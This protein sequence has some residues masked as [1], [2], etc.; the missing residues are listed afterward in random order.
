MYISVLRNCENPRR[1]LDLFNHHIG[2][3]EENND[4]QRDCRNEGS[5]NSVV[6]SLSESLTF[7]ST[8]FG[9]VYSFGIEG[10]KKLNDRPIEFTKN[11]IFRKNRN[12]M[13]SRRSL[14]NSRLRPFESIN[15]YVGSQLLD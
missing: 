5:D 1:L 11:E 7:K 4:G 12:E 9:A 13:A 2:L 10:E 15:V 14:I 6:T 8:G 3:K